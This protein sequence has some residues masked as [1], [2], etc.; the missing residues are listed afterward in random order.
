ML[1]LN[2]FWQQNIAEQKPLNCMMIDAD[3]FKEVNDTFG[4]DAGDIVLCEISKLLAHSVRND[5]FVARL[6]G[7]EFFIICPNTN[8]QDCLYLAD[9]VLQRVKAL[10]VQT[11]DGACQ[12]SL[13]VGV[14]EKTAEMQTTEDLMKCADDSVYKAKDAGKGCVQSVQ[15]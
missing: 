8:L 14:A 15:I 11:G 2:E 1:K 12:G 4:H 10:S 9:K 6:G 7:D 3:H 13:S 5:D